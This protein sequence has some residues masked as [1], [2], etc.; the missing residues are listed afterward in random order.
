MSESNVILTLKDHLS[1]GF[2]SITNALNAFNKKG[3]YIEHFTHILGRVYFGE[4][5]VCAPVQS[6]PIRV[7]WMISSFRIRI[8]LQV[9]DKETAG[10]CLL[11]LFTDA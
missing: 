3:E 9:K 8:M 1:Q 11:F 10:I 4:A 7:M 2:N 6:P 5:I